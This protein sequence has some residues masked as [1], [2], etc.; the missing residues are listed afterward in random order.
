MRT[1]S[2]SMVY[3]VKTAIAG[4][5]A[6]AATCMSIIMPVQTK[7]DKHSIEDEEMLMCAASVNCF[8][9]CGGRTVLGDGDGLGELLDTLES[10][11]VVDL[12]RN[13]LG[14]ELVHRQKLYHK[15]ELNNMWR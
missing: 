3:L 2:A 11:G 12:V 13:L 15:N 7:R 5:V 9:A 6:T 8:Q 4:Q 1:L 10:S 14:R